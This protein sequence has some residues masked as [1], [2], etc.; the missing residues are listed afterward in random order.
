[1][2]ESRGRTSGCDAS[3]TTSRETIKDEGWSVKLKTTWL[4]SELRRTRLMA[5]PFVWCLL[6]SGLAA[7]AED[8][9]NEEGP[10]WGGWQAV[11]CPAKTNA[12]SV[13]PTSYS[14]V[15]IGQAPTMPTVTSPS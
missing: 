4:G 7:K 13:V 8:Y 15:T 6:V 14:C 1:M 9:C 2:R 3:A 12:G 5:I 10:H 11:T